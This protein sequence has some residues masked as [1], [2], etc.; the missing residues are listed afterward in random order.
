MV[1][2]V[3]EIIDSPVI[4][5]YPGAQTVAR[6]I[7]LL[8]AL[9]DSHP[10]RGLSELS[11]HVGLNK[12]TTHR[13]LSALE[14]EGLI[15]RG[16]AAGQYRLGVEL[17]ALGGCAMRAN[18]LREV[19]RPELDLL[20]RESGENA[21]LEIMVK[22]RVMILDE[23]S[24][25]TLQAA[26]LDIGVRLPLHATSTGKLLLAYRPPE[27][28]ETILAEPLPA[29]TPRTI[30][31]PELLRAQ[32]DEIRAHGYAKADGELDVGFVAVAAPVYNADRVV[33]A[34]VSV[35]GPSLRLTEE[36]L[37]GIVALVQVA[38]RR[39]SRRL[40]YRPI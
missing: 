28:I 11:E 18:E 31:E 29:L 34:A 9:D 20:M 22:R 4:E 15:M 35:G 21:V 17:I 30:V 14:A 37:P 39:I 24:S 12:T 8:R 36:R 3:E 19:S 6:A 1:C 16:S 26:P 10:E 25:Q 23:V 32:L 13:L 33:V 27:E 5:A 2:I 7:A 40:G 38:G